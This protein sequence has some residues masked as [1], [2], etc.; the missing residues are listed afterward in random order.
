MGGLIEGN[1]SFD[2]G[3]AGIEA[4]LNQIGIGGNV[5]DDNTI[6]ISGGSTIACN[7]IDGV[8]SCPP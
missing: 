8:L 3:G 5:V 7:V 2:N 6:G 1:V 4:P